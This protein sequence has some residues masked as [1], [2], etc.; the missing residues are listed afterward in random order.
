MFE[1]VSPL[2]IDKVADRIAGAMV[3]WAYEHSEDE[4]RVAVEVLI[5]HGKCYIIAESSFEFQFEEVREI[6]DRIAGKQFELELKVVPQNIHLE[7]NQQGLVRCGDNGIFK[8]VRTS[9]EENELSRFARYMYD[10]VIASDGKYI[11]NK[12]IKIG[13]PKEGEFSS[14][15][16]TVCQ[17]GIQYD[18]LRKAISSFFKN[19]D[20]TVKIN[21]LGYWEA[22]LNNDSGATNRK[23]GSDMGRGATGGG[24]MGK[25]LSKADVS[26]NIFLYLLLNKPQRLKMTIHNSNLCCMLDMLDRLIDKSKD[27]DSIE[28]SCSIGDEYV[29]IMDEK[30]KFYDIVRIVKEYI[31]TCYGG[32]EKL[33]EWGLV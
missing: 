18:N 10:N 17:S 31:F 33:A 9:S 13:I 11:L 16:L 26:V 7:K 1:K 4:P 3:D 28:T 12:D 22:D 14:S 27:C 30:I 29:F 21:P 24:L 25:D 2:H 15:N 8:G 23:L 19:T 5:G 32:F 20:Y 6:V